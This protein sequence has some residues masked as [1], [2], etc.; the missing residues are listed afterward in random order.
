MTT[1]NPVVANAIACN[2]SDMPKEFIS[3]F[4]SELQRLV[5]EIGKSMN[6][7]ETEAD[8]LKGQARRHS[9]EMEYEGLLTY[10]RNAVAGLQALTKRVSETISTL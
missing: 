10:E 7:I 8:R 4:R 6:R 5:Q 9:N 2:A 1:T 3:I